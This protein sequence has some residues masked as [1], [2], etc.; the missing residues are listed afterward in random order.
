GE[1][2]RAIKAMK[3]LACDSAKKVMSGVRTAVSHFISSDTSD[4]KTPITK[5]EDRVETSVNDS[6]ATQCSTENCPL[7]S[8]E[9]AIL[10]NWGTIK[11]HKALACMLSLAQILLTVGLTTKLNFTLAEYVANYAP[12][13]VLSFLKLDCANCGMTWEAIILSLTFAGSMSTSYVPAA[14]IFA[15]LSKTN[16][17]EAQKIMQK[18]KKI[19]SDITKYALTIAAISTCSLFLDDIGRA[20]YK[21]VFGTFNSGLNLLS[22]TLGIMT[23]GVNSLSN[24]IKNTS[25][26]KILNATFDTMSNAT[27]SCGNKIV[28][29]KN[30]ALDYFVNIVSKRSTLGSAV[31]SKCGEFTLNGGEMFNKAT[32]GSDFVT[33]LE[34]KITHEEIVHMNK[35]I[36]K[37]YSA[38]DPVMN[39][40]EKISKITPEELV[41]MTINMPFDVIKFCGDTLV[42][43]ETAALDCFAN[44][45]GKTVTLGSAGLS[46]CGEFALGECKFFLNLTKDLAPW[47]AKTAIT[48]PFYVLKTVGSTAGNMATGFVGH[49]LSGWKY[50]LGI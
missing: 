25:F 5:L 7:S 14:I 4:Q 10:N 24:F 11:D 32:K 31:A 37:L 35:W 29:L 39:F 16:N 44:I 41:R 12:E 18:F 23:N 21:A 38:M 46:K 8:Y 15:C 42:K 26:K 48:A 1:K 34:E 13:S 17:A 28:T 45:A 20:L 9:K 2:M 22:K 33:N 36:K 6:G 30:A 19:S 43:V 40:M 50:A 49:S 47:I 27:K 3:N